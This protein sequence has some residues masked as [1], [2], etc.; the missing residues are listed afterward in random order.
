MLAGVIALAAPAAA[1]E[2]AA[3]CGSDEPWIGLSVAKL[4]EAMRAQVA[5]LPAGVGFVV[6]HIEPGGPAAEAGLRRYD[7]LWKLGDQWLINEAQLGTLLRIRGSGS[8]VALTVV[9]GGETVEVPLQIGQMPA[10]RLVRHRWNP[11][12]I[13]I[14]PTGIPGMPRQVI[15]PGNRVAEISRKDGSVAK[16]RYDNERAH[17]RIA[18]ADGEV[19]FD[20]PV[21]RSGEMQVPESWRCAVHALIRT[22]RRSEERDWQPRRPRPRVVLPPSQPAR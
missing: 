13:P 9:R 7:I 12:E 18:A 19:I 16:L 1:A 11:E 5:Q 6:T 4:D 2:P 21:E 17:V 10:E 3:S 22:M 15:Y 14:F 20:G 8:T